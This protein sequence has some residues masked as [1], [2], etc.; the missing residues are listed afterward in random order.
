MDWYW[1]VSLC[2]GG[3]IIAGLGVRK[4]LKIKKNWERTFRNGKGIS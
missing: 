3:L 1:I 2:A 4:I